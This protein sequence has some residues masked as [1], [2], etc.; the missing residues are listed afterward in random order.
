MRSGE[1]SG[2]KEGKSQNVVE[3]YQLTQCL[4]GWG[5]IRT[6]GRVAPTP[7][8]K[9]GAFNHSATHP[10]RAQSRAGEALEPPASGRQS[11][12]AAEG[13]AAGPGN[14]S[15]SSWTSR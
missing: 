7:V 14:S 4:G 1:T 8:L 11:S 13:A 12:A 2:E 3:L 6:H 5:G 9:T 10:A 15:K